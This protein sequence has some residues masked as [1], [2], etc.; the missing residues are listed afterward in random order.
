MEYVKLDDLRIEI[1]HL[2]HTLGHHQMLRK[3]YVK[4][5]DNYT[6]QV[7]VCQRYNR[8]EEMK[9]FEA[10][11]LYQKKL[12]ILNDETIDRLAKEL[13]DKRKLF[14]TQRRYIDDYARMH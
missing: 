3:D 14:E 6:K 11:L 1:Q 9:G 12:Q 10:K 13:N 8:Y 5:I 4:I 7:D 2:E